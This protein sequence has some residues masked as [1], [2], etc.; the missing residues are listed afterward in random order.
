M[1]VRNVGDRAGVDVVQLYLHD[2]VAQVT[3]PVVR[4]IGY[5]RVP[6]EPGEARR[7]TFDVPAD[8]AAFTGRDSQHVVEPGDLELRLSASSSQVRHTVRARLAG[9][10]R[11]VGHGRQLIARATLD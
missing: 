4:L 1:T 8:L 10:E 11:V 3:R 9:P 7:V 6:V 2:P 5:A